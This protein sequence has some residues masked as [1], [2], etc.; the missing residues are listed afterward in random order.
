MA[1]PTA[2]QIATYEAA[3]LADTRSILVDRIYAEHQVTDEPQRIH[4]LSVE[5]VGTYPDTRLE[6]L[7]MDESRPRDRYTFIVDLWDIPLLLELQFPE[8]E[9][10]NQMKD[11]IDE[12]L[13]AWNYGLPLGG[14]FRIDQRTRPAR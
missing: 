13:Q 9:P 14:V 1:P 4:F 5:L 10:G 7:L 6:V 11:L 3:V 2:Q 8:H 12:W